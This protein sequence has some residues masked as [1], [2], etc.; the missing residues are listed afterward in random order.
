MSS[1]W[2]TLW[3]AEYRIVLMRNFEIS[4]SNDS[5]RLNPGEDNQ[6][7]EEK[8]KKGECSC[9]S[10]M[11]ECCTEESE[12]LSLLVGPLESKRRTRDFQILGT[13]FK[14]W[15]LDLG[16]LMCFDGQHKLRVITITR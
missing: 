16:S 12:R 15:E 2:Y 14:P 4:P 5:K 9:D 3:N 10:V 6:P 7:S 1:T 8:V 13:W 11:M